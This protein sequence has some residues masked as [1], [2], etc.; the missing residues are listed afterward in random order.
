MQCNGTWSESLKSLY[1]DDAVIGIAFE[2][3]YVLEIQNKIFA[4]ISKFEIQR[5]L[6]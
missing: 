4:T 3:V 5:L 1:D 6:I 2:F